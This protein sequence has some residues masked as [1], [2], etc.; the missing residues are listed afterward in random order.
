MG[1]QTTGQW[2]DVLP[3]QGAFWTQP[4]KNWDIDQR[5]LHASRDCS[6]ISRKMIF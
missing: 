5:G 3:V 4:E 6:S 1:R 2:I